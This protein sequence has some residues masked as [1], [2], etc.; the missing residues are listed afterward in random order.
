MNLIDSIQTLQ[1]LRVNNANEMSIKHGKIQGLIDAANAFLDDLQDK[2]SETTEF[3]LQEVCLD[4]GKVISGLEKYT[5]SDKD[6]INALDV[7]LEELRKQ[8]TV[9]EKCQGDGKVLRTRMC[10]EDDR[11]D[12][13]DPNDWITCPECRGTGEAKK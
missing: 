6:I 3:L 11:P 7:A 10:T 12:P 2:D 5:K 1:K 4:V 8:N 9:C 13:N